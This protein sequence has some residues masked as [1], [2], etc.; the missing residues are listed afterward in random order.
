MLENY[1][2]MKLSRTNL[3]DQTT[4]R[5][6]RGNVVNLPFSFVPWE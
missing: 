5:M 4:D 2:G 6:A 1:L 3:Q